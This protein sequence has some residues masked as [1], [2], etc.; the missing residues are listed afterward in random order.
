MLEHHADV[1]AL[2]R[3]GTRVQ[4]VQFRAALGITDE[5]PVD[6]QATGIDAFEVVDAPEEGRLARSGRADQTGHLAAS[7]LER[8]A[9]EHLHGAEALADPVGPHHRRVDGRHMRSSPGAPGFGVG[10]PASVTGAFCAS[11]S[12]CS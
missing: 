5:I 11:A 4:F 9:L 8:D 3:G 1:A 7:D 10:L 2:L 6:V 12:A